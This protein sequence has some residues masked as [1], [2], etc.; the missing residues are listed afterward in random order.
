MATVELRSLSK[1]YGGRAAWALAGVT[2]RVERGEAVALLGANGAGKTTVMEI[3]S[4]LL[5]PSSGQ[6]AVMGR[7]VVREAAAVRAAIGVVRQAAGL[8]PSARLAKLAAL[9]ARLRGGSTAE[10]KRR[11]TEMFKLLGLEDATRLRVRELSGGMRRRLDIGLG[12]MGDPPVLLLDEPAAGLDP[13]SKAQIYAELRRRCESGA[14]VLF[15]SQSLEETR[16]LANRVAFL[17]SGRLLDDDVP[18]SALPALFSHE[19]VI[20]DPR[21]PA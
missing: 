18:P 2:L 19:M 8:P 6:A 1:A 13:S 5:R 16:A 15:T 9:H 11:A 14:A 21:V 7:D 10:A 17:E 4:T 12:L 3:L 20:A